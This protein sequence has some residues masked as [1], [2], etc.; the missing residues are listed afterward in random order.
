MTEAE[1][2]N[3]TQAKLVDLFDYED[4]EFMYEREE[5]EYYARTEDSKRGKKRTPHGLKTLLERLNWAFD[6]MGGYISH[7]RL[8]EYK[9]AMLDNDNAVKTINGRLVSCNTYLNYLAK[10]YNNQNIMRLKVGG[11]SEDPKQYI[12]NVI[13]RADYEFLLTEALK[14][15]DPNLWLGIKIMGT[16]GVRFCELTQVKVEHIKHGYL[17]VLGKGAKCRRIYFPKTAREEILKRL[18]HLDNAD[19]GYVMRYWYPKRGKKTGAFEA[20]TRDLGNFNNYLTFYKRFSYLLSS[21]G[22]K[23]GLDPELMHAHGFRHFFAK[24]FLKN[25]LDISLLADILGHSSLEVTRIYLKMTSREQAE[26]V[27]ETVTW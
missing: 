19:S 21:L 16:T 26:V 9:K 22:Q 23:L 20:N 17:D 11:L 24:E 25:R 4:I 2:F 13:S 5:F 1:E 8:K 18:S 27:D 10:K 15:K 14:E 6:G 7:N 3:S 12:D